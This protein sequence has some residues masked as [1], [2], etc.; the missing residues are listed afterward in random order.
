MKK[1]PVLNASESSFI[2]FVSYPI[3]ALCGPYRHLIKAMMIPMQNNNGS[4][5]TS[6]PLNPVVKKHILHD[7]IRNTPCFL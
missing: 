7:S 6:M 2:N 1:Q 3:F 5:F 4:L